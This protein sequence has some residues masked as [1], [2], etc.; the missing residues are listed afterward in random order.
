MSNQTTWDTA[1]FERYGPGLESAARRCMDTIMRYQQQAARKNALHSNHT[2][3]YESSALAGLMDW[4]RSYRKGIATVEC[5]VNAIKEA[6]ASEAAMEEAYQI[7]DRRS[8]D[9]EWFA[10]FWFQGLIDDG[11]LVLPEGNDR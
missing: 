11:L 7:A 3:G 2:K 10:W 4:L 5:W 6:L 8:G 1:V 9:D